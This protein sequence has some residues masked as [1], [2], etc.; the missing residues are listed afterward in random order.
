MGKVDIAAA[1]LEFVIEE[2]SSKD[3]EKKMILS[4]KVFNEQL[5]L[6]E[7]K[8]LIRFTKAD[9]SLVKITRRGEQFLN[10]YGT[11]HAKY[12]TVPAQQ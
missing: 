4:S 5:K 1:I 8:D 9:K 12:L 10:L 6:L 7:S 2:S 3:L 11:I